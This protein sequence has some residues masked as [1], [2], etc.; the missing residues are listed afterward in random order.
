MEDKPKEECAEC[1]VAANR[2]AFSGKSAD[3]LWLL[4]LAN[5]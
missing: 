3:I 4:H 2:P 5:M 1:L